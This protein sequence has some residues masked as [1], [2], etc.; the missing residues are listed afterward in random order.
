MT[1]DTITKE[2][3]PVTPGKNLTGF[4]VCTS[5]NKTL[6]FPKKK[7]TKDEILATG[8]Q[9][10]IPP[11]A[12]K[13][14]ALK[15]KFRVP[16]TSH[17]HGTPPQTSSSALLHRRGSRPSYSAAPM[18][19]EKREA[20]ERPAGENEPERP[21]ELRSPG[22]ATTASTAAW[23]PLR[24]PHPHLGRGRAAAGRAQGAAAPPPPPLGAKAAAMFPRPLTPLTSGHGCHAVAMAAA[25]AGPL[26]GTARQRGSEE[27]G[28]GF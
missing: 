12:T 19:A 17:T 6:F 23:P 2:N 15:A 28:G 1:T 3:H 22:A 9:L 8:L 4:C 14:A 24:A 18:P 21:E 7:D 27:P 26:K 13:P 5:Q 16:Y 11:R 25:R 10:F 20:G